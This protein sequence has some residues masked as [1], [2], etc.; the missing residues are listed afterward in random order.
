MRHEFLVYSQNMT[1]GRAKSTLTKK[2]N[3]DAMVHY[4]TKYRLPQRTTWCAHSSLFNELVEIWISYDFV[5]TLVI[6]LEYMMFFLIPKVETV[7]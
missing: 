4:V 6:T 3:E 5:L 1:R 2:P 7:R